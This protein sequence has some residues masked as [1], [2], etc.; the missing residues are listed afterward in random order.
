MDPWTLAY[1]AGHRDMNITK[2]YVHPQE[3]T[4]R[5]AMDRAR[6]VEGG[7]TF[8]HTAQNLNPGKPAAGSQPLDAEELS[9]APGETRT[10]DLLVRSQPLY[11]PELRARALPILSDPHRS[12][13]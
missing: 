10:P 5:A 4:I 6:G 7:H 13:L 9:G 8:G 11:P 12:A 2:R 3:Q 1:L